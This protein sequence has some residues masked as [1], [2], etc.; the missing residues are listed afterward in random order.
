MDREELTK[1]IKNGPVRILM[2]DGNSYE[3]PGTEF[4][5][6][7]DIAAYTLYRADDGKMRTMILPLVTMSGV[8]P[9]SA[10]I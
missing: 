7:S 5:V 1:L 3:V 8:E 6:V 4:A 2:N 10:D 9:L